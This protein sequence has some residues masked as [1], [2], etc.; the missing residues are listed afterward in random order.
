MS[1]RKYG[2]VFWR[3]PDSRDKATSNFLKHVFGIE[4][5]ITSCANEVH[6]RTTKT[7]KGWVS[8]QISL[9]GEIVDVIWRS[10]RVVLE[11]DDL[12]FKARAAQANRCPD[13]AT[14]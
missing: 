8:H 12:M 7:A 3:L 1:G 9:E 10:D 13:R 11:A 2:D 14:A 4:S 6:G 5:H